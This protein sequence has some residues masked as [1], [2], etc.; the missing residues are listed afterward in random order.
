[1]NK[2]IKRE[3]K[4]M[5]LQ[6]AEMYLQLAKIYKR[7]EDADKETTEHLME[8]ATTIEYQIIDMKAELYL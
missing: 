6:L 5:Y 3:I 7:M 2:K 4:W 1:M 8:R